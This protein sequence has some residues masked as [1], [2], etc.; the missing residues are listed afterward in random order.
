M[1][2]LSEATDYILTTD[3]FGLRFRKLANNP[4]T[5]GSQWN[6]EAVCPFQETSYKRWTFR[7][8][9]LREAEYF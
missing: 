6:L 1:N 2:C 3:K 7:L 4:D 8:T 5:D 9:R